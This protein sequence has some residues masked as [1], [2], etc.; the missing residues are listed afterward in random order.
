M[1]NTWIILPIVFQLASAVLLLFFW[2]YIKVQKILSITLSLIGLGTSLWLFT[3]VYDDG[4]LVM[5]SGNW[6]A[7]FGISFV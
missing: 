6:S 2:S 4:I 5:Q 3:S 1:S 7:P